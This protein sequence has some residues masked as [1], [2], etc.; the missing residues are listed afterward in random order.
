MLSLIVITFSHAFGLSI[1][2]QYRCDDLTLLLIRSNLMADNS[3][4]VSKMY[5]YIM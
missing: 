4:H 5:V 3:S 2:I 1:L